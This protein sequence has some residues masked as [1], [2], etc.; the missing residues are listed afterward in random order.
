VASVTLEF[1]AP[2]DS[3]IVALRIFEAADPL[4]PFNEIARVTNIGVAPTYITEYTTTAAASATDW[5]AISWENAGGVIS[6]LS[7]PVQGGKSSLV[8]IITDRVMLRDESLNR[9]VVEQEAEWA[10]GDY[11][12]QDPFAVDPNTV[13]W[14]T[15]RGLV[16]LVLVRSYVS[17]RLSSADSY[18]W[19]AGLVSLDTSAGSGAAAEKMIDRLIASANS[20]LNRNYSVMLMTEEIAVA[21]GFKSITSPLTRVTG[22]DLTRGILSVSID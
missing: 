20:D 6:P 15:E 3:D 5:F 18:K 1:L 21:G 10:I 2:L 19:T 7:V 8:G 16:T 12:Q 22:V 14:R 11:F 13:N 4:A 17:T 9:N